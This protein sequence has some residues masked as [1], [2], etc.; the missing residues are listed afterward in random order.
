[1]L[2]PDFHPEIPEE[3]VKAAFPNGNM[4]LRL[5]DTQYTKPELLDTQPNQLWSGDITKVLGPTKWTYEYPGCLQPLLCRLV[6]RRT[7]I[8]PSG[9]RIDRSHLRSPKH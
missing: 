7:R 8:P 2:R 4:Y 9:R 1:M 5:R 6:D 3:K